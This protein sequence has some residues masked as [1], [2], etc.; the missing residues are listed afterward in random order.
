[1]S[2]TQRLFKRNMMKSFI[3]HLGLANTYAF[4]VTKET[5]KKYHLEKVSDLEI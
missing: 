3:I 2:E 4:M 5:A 1:M